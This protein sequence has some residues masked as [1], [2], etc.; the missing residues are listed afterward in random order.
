MAR[1]ADIGLSGQRRGEATW[2]GMYLPESQVDGGRFGSN[3]WEIRA[4]ELSGW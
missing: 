3:G 1:G 4:P 2:L